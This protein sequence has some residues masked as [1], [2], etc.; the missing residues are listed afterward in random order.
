MPDRYVHSSNKMMYIL[1]KMVTVNSLIL[2]VSSNLNLVASLM[3]IMASS[4]LLLVTEMV[5]FI[6]LYLQ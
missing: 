2:N 6:K 1:L 4:N 5:S 3:E